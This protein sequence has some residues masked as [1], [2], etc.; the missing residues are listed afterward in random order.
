MRALPIFLV[1]LVAACAAEPESRV[2]VRGHVVIGH[3]VRAL[4]EC[5]AGS[6]SWLIDETRGEL[7]RWY[8]TLSSEPY[9]PLFFEL[10]VTVRTRPPRASARTTWPRSG[11][12]PFAARSA[13]VS[14]ATR[15]CRD[16]DSR[17]A[18]TSLP[19]SWSRAIRFAVQCAGRAAADT[20][21]AD[22]TGRRRVH[23]LRGR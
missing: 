16:F 8:D 14:A 4:T 13:K 1:P 12:P 15:T 3:E 23:P 18:A 2:I 6:E 5:G 11:R 21:R 10:A 20:D 7:R 19:G 17:R 22:R 9:E